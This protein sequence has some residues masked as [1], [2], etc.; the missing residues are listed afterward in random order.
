MVHV[1]PAS[2][3]GARTG[4]LQMLPFLC[5]SKINDRSPLLLEKYTVL[6]SG[7]NAG[8]ES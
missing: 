8:A 5:D 4:G 6:S 7:V 3:N 1:V 2:G